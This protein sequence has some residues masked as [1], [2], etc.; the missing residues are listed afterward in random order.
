MFDLGQAICVWRKELSCTRL[1]PDSL[2]ELESHLRDDIARE[3]RAGANAETAFQSSVQRLGPPSRLKTEFKKANPVNLLLFILR[4]A[5]VIVA[6][7]DTGLCLWLGAG[8]RDCASL[9]CVLLCLAL[10]LFAGPRLAKN[11]FSTMLRGQIFIG[12]GAALAAFSPLPPAFGL[13]LAVFGCAWPIHRLRRQSRA[14]VHV[15][16]S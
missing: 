9:Y 7:L 1:S 16:A 2:D 6:L 4:L 10:P 14:S 15:A 5:L 3:I 13:S 12:L 8:L 11:C